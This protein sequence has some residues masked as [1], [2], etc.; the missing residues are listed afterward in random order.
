MR[1]LCKYHPDVL[2][3]QLHTVNIAVIAEVSCEE[4]HECWVN[5]VQASKPDSLVVNSVMK[6]V[7]LCSNQ[8]PLSV[9]CNFFVIFYYDLCHIQKFLLISG[10]L[11]VWLQK[12]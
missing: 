4:K 7:K 6:R 5:S 3:A 11:K 12:T 1:R 2:I 8:M 9:V 10:Q